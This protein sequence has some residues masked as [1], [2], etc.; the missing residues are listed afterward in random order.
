[1]WRQ[2]MQTKWIAPSALC[3]AW[4]PSA[5]S[6]KAVN[7]ASLISPDG[8]GELAVLDPRRGRETWPSIGTL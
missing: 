6:R 2:S 5:V 3:A 1:M 4:W 7:S 8:H